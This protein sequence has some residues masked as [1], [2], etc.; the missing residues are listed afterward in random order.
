MV[1]AA[2]A[3][4]RLRGLDAPGRVQP[5]HTGGAGAPGLRASAR[6][7]GT[8]GAAIAAGTPIRPGTPSPRPATDA[9]AASTI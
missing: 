1:D 3:R 4:A 8:D 7:T 5:V 2:I 9:L 6:R